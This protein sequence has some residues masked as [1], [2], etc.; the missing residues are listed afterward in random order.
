MNQNELEEKGRLKFFYHCPESELPIRNVTDNDKNGLKTEPHIE[1]GVENYLNRCYQDY[2]QDA[3]DNNEKYI[4]WMT[5][6]RNSKLPEYNERRII[7]YLVLQ[8]SKE[9]DEDRFYFKGKAHIFSFEDSIQVKDLGYFAKPRKQL[10]EEENSKKILD[11]FKDKK[12]IVKECVKEIKKMD[13]E[14]KTCYRVT[15]DFDCKFKDECLRWK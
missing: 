2:L 14:N 7:G 15:Y 6:C 10:V 3:I 5:T 12:N 8:E 11:H 13:P 9:I 1:I 4:F